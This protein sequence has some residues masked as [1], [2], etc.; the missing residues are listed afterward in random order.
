M[1]IPLANKQPCV[2]SGAR[3]PDVE[4]DDEWRNREGWLPY[5]NDTAGL[6]PLEPRDGYHR[7][8]VGPAST[9]LIR[10]RSAVERLRHGLDPSPMV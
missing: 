6:K 1:H 8:F 2:D 9:L 7:D 3:D 5:N 4:L 10:D